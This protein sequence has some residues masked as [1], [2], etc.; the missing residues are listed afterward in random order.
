MRTKGINLFEE[1]WIIKNSIC[2]YHKS[3][4]NETINVD[5][6][7]FSGFFSA[8]NTFQEEVFPNQSVNYIDFVESR[9]IFLKYNNLFFVV[10]DFVTKPVNRSLT[11]LN[12]ITLEIMFEIQ[13]DEKFNKIVVLEK[14]LFDTDEIEDFLNPIVDEIIQNHKLIDDQTNRFDT[15]GIITVLRELRTIIKNSVYSD[16][17]II[18]D[19]PMNVD[20]LIKLVEDEK[21]LDPLEIQS[22]DYNLINTFSQYYLGQLATNLQNYSIMSDKMKKLEFNN[23]LLNFFTTNYEVLSKFRLIDFFVT[24]FITKF[25]NTV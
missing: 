7:L 12:N 14:E 15:L 21:A 23:N 9:L 19:F 8:F 5:N 25:K 22:A 3:W 11:Q 6:I 4:S 10:R 24:K 20:W 17:L 13:Y 2:Y 18:Q 1:L 16:I